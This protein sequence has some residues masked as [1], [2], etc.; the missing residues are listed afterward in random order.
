M[1]SDVAN[2]DA[3]IREQAARWMLQLEEDFGPTQRVMFATWLKLSPRHTEEFLL[4]SA[5]WTQL[6]LL[7]PHRR[8]DLGALLKAAGCPA[9]HSLP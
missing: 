8:I 7:D 5:L 2:L 9:H 1:G 4:V 6:D 3:A